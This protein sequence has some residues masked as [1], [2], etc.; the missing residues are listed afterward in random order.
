MCYNLVYYRTSMDIKA[1]VLPENNSRF[2]NDRLDVIKKYCT[3]K[4]VLDLGCVDHMAIQ[5]SGAVWMHKTIKEVARELIGVDFEAEEV[6]KLNAKGYDIVV[7]NVES[8]ELNR[9]FEVCVAG[10]LI[11]HLS[12]PGLFLENVHHHL[13]DG[14]TL[15]VTTPN[16]FA[17]RYHFTHF[18]YGRGSINPQHTFYYDYYTLRELCER[19]WFKL[20]ESYY[21]FDGIGNKL[22]RVIIR[23]FMLAR[24]SYAPRILFVLTKS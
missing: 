4:S 14:G 19:H 16:A 3:G 12:N 17:L 18:L 7:G 11:E 8:I 23:L 20:R 2:I 21:F 10:E 24:K 22:R 15:I 9:T 6:A 1:A 5:E 13:V